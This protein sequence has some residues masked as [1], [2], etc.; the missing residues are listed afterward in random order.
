MNQEARASQRAAEHGFDA[1]PQGWLNGDLMYAADMTLEK[2]CNA[3][4][5]TKPSGCS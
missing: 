5:G 3:Y 4:T 1:T 2:I